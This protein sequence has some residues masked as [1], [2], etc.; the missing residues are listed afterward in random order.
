[1]TKIVT[2][3]KKSR[4]FACFV[5]KILEKSILTSENALAFLAEAIFADFTACWLKREAF[6]LE[7][8]NPETLR[9]RDED[10]PERHDL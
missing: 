5:K 4:G 1:M 6:N 3:Q 10:R 2:K 9:S 7:A 8:V